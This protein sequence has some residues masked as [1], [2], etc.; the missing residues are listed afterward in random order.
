MLQFVY[1]PLRVF[2]DFSYTSS[3]IYRKLNVR[4]FSVTLQNFYKLNDWINIR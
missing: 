1:S 3:V 2:A 4:I